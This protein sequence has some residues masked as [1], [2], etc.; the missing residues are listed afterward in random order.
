MQHANFKI[1][2]QNFFL[3]IKTGKI[4]SNFLW[5]PILKAEEIWFNKF[6]KLVIIYLMK[7]PIIFYSLCYLTSKVSEE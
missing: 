4:N 2:R 5:L 3:S 1:S 7:S 6:T